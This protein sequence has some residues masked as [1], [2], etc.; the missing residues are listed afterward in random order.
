MTLRWMLLAPLFAM[1]A[2]CEG[3]GALLDPALDV[4]SRCS[5]CGWIESKQQISPAILEPHSFAVYEYKVRMANG[6]S[7]LFREKTSAN[8]RVGERLIVIGARD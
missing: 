4:S 2:A 3:P 6:S 7:S 1:L 8:W 5:H